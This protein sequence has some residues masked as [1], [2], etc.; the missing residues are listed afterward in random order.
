M[1]KI[2]GILSALL[3]LAIIAV[4]IYFAFRSVPNSYNPAAY[5]VKINGEE[6]NDGDFVVLK[7]GENLIEIKKPFYESNAVTVIVVVFS[8]GRKNNGL[9]RHR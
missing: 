5:S 1:K 8:V 9:R 4:A 6:Y 2:I 3:V 7:Y